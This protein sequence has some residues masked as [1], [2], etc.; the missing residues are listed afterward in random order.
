MKASIILATYNW[1]QAL[2]AILYSLVP[3]LQAYPEIELIIADD[4]S[5]PD[6][7]IVINK[8]K[9]QIPTLQHIWHSDEGFRK[10][11]ILNKAVA[12]SRGEYL[13]FLDGDCVPFPDYI[14]QHLKLCEASYFVAGNRVLLSQKFTQVV[15]ANP[16]KITA[17]FNWGLF[18]WTVARLNHKVNKLLP[19]IR[20]GS[21]KWRYSRSTNWKYPKGCNFAVARQDFLAINGFDESFSGWGHEDADLFIRLLHYGLKIKDGRFAIPVLHMWHV[22]FDRSKEQSNY[23]RLVDRLND[24]KCV[25]ATLGIKQYLNSDY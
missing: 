17:I 12:A 24:E 20:L 1:P 6:T 19:V 2:D 22:E 23:Q 10:S 4:G 9:N 25:Q 5:K 15:L 11:M 21:G 7:K 16:A 8:Y 18:R 13:I 14:F 3:Q